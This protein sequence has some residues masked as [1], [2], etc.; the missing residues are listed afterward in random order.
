MTHAVD[1]CSAGHT[2]LMR[3]ITAIGHAVRN[4]RQQ[5]GALVLSD[6]V[7]AFLSPDA[8]LQLSAV[9]GKHLIPLGGGMCAE[10]VCCCCATVLALWIAVG[11]A[12]AHSGRAMSQAIGSCT[13]RSLIPSLLSMPA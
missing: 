7:K 12:S 6:A 9:Q 4:R 2:L 5:L 8:V 3:L 11:A 10:C 13:A 1:R